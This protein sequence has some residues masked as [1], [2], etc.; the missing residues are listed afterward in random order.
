MTAPSAPAPA[1]R[2]VYD[3]LDPELYRR[4]PHDAWAWMR[5]HEPVYRDEANGLWAVTRHADVLDVERR[6]DVFLSGPAYR[7]LPSPDE[8]NMIAQ[9]DPRHGQQRRLVSREFTPAAVRTRADEIRSLVVELLDEALEAAPGGRGELEVVDRL[10]AQL[11][12]R[13]TCRLLGFPEAQWRDLKSWSERLMRLDTMDRDPEV[14]LGVVTACFEFNSQLDDLLAERAGCPMGDLLSTWA[15]AE[16]DG[17][18]LDRMSVFHETGLF[19]SGGSETTRT[20]IAHGLR[21]FCDHPD[22]WERLAEAPQAVPAAVEEL[23]RWVTPLNNFFRTAAVDTEVGGQAVGAGE[24]VILLYPSANRDEA[25][26]DDPFRFD[27]ART[28][29]HHVAFGYGTHFC[30]GANLA[31]QTLRLLL[32]EL[33]RRITDL[34]V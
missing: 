8:T 1:A 3:L 5:A 18:P 27:I 21:A 29:N 12:A 24:R 30:L 32:E 7:A 2:P 17:E 34:E 19:I 22:Q 10:A 13:L 11:P 15:N 9:D 16:I 23:L 4:D 14:A 25:V 20:V 28:P 31:R 26:F 6:S 33:P